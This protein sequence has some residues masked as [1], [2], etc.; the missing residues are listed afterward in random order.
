MVIPTEMS[1]KST[2]AVSSDDIEAAVNAL[3]EQD[4]LRMAD[5]ALRGYTFFVA[6]THPLAGTWWHANDPTGRYMRG[7]G[8]LSLARCITNVWK[9]V[10]SV[11]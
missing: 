6:Q 4:R 5:L 2:H 3:N 9:E 1:L 7:L 10:R 11:E 8:S